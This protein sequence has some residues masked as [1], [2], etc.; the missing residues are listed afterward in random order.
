MNPC[1]YCGRPLRAN[2]D[3]IRLGA[4]FF[5]VHRKCG[6]EIRSDP[7]FPLAR[8]TADLVI[9]YELLRSLET[10][11]SVARMLAP[12]NTKDTDHA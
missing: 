8:V 5:T 4:G 2:P 12:L 11:P 6:K 7:I 1:D 10:I 9:W 3:T